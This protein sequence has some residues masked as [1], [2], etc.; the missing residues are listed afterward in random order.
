MSGNAIAVAIVVGGTVSLIS[1]VLATRKGYSF[2]IW[3]L[4]SATGSTIAALTV[5]ALLPNVEA[6]RLSVAGRRRQRAIGNVIGLILA[7]IGFCALMALWPGFAWSW[8]A[9]VRVAVLDLAIGVVGLLGLDRTLLR[10]FVPRLPEVLLAFFLLSLVPLVLLAAGAILEQA[11]R[12]L[13]GPL[14]YGNWLLGNPWQALAAVVSLLGVVAL[15][16]VLWMNRDVIWAV[17]RKLILEALHRRVVLV[18]LVFFVILMPILP[19]VLTTEGSQK[20]HVQLVLLYSMVLAL[21]LLSLLAIFMTAASMCSEV[22][23]KQVHIT[24][25]KPLKRW[26]FLLGK[27]FGAVVMCTA[28][29]G[30][31][32]LGSY[33]L[34]SYVAQPPDLEKLPPDEAQKARKEWNALAEEVFVSRK[35]VVAKLPDVSAQA[36]EMAM[37]K[38][39]KQKIP[40]AVN[41]AEREFR[42]QLLFRSQTVPAGAGLGW[43]FGGLEPGQDG[44]LFVR[45]RAFLSGGQDVRG[46]WQAF[47]P[48]VVGAEG[49]G[50]KPRLVAEPIGEP[51]VSPPAGWAPNAFH[52]IKFPAR[53]IA[54]DGSIWLRFFNA[55]SGGT[56]I[57]DVDNPVEVMQREG[58]FPLNYYRSLVII[59]FHVALLAALGVM[60]GALFSFPVA[61]LLV[62]CLFI[63]GL[64][65]PWFTKEFVEPNIYARLTT[66]TA[67]VD[68]AWRAFAGG[69]MAVM[70]NFGSFSPLGNLVNGKVVG[71]G[72]V[73]SAGAVLFCIKGGLALLLGIY[74]YSRR[75]LARTVM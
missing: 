23:N 45:F 24:D 43:R 41:S 52:E 48:R 6:S 16:F 62:V 46:V 31:M 38:L 67:Y 26:Q 5:L 15:V 51:V 37:E 64:I 13:S 32:T 20:S 55:G 27:W 19:F 39:A 60:A 65:G 57:F 54:E 33:F 12:F 63:G 72:Q 9:L 56:V 70:P 18:L 36:R 22:E 74:F 34:V 3:L 10:W 1:A 8:P 25:P 66:V 44:W 28:V 59:M 29:L 40:W 14:Q 30:V 75:E 49:E 69:I 58:N 50:T 2:I 71:M 11:R 68:R 73:A 17:A 35:S 7:P 61:S 47:R 53:L 42:R 21:V 4:A